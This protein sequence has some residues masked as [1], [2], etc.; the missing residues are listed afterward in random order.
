MTALYL[1]GGGGHAS[2]MLAVY[3]SEGWRPGELWVADDGEPFAKRFQNRAQVFR[4]T[5]DDAVGMDGSFV[6]AVGFPV[7]KAMIEERAATANVVW[8][9][10]AVHADATVHPTAHLGQGVI[11]FGQTW[12]S[13]LVEL[14]DH[15]H[16]GY[17]ATIGHDTTVG[18]LSSIM[19]GASIGGEVTVG[20]RVLV[21]ANSTILQGVTLGSGSTVGA[22]AVVTADVPPAV[23]VVGVPA[24]PQLGAT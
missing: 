8:Q 22:G 6:L 10:A 4:G 13:P 23:T 9:T 3:E 14:D 16:V 12:L 2:D 11:V 15:V 18:R 5:I 1:L 19:P 24:R 7:S 21:G 20:D 17:G